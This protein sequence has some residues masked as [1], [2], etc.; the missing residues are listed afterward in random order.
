[1]SLLDFWRRDDALELVWHS[2]DFGAK[3]Y[4]AGG[5]AALQ[6]RRQR[7]GSPNWRLLMIV[8]PRTPRDR[9]RR[10]GPGGAGGHIMR[11]AADIT[12]ALLRQ[13]LDKKRG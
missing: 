8:S 6:Q 12:P 5:T 4:A 10:G 11:R 7:A 9:D 2:I 1:V 13:E 3:G